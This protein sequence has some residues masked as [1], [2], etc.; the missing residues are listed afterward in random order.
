MFTCH[1]TS[2]WPTFTLLSRLHLLVG[3]HLP[4][5]LLH[6]VNDR[7]QAWDGGHVSILSLLDLSA[8]FDTIDHDILIKRL[9]TTFGFSGTVLDWF[10]SYLSFRTQSVFLGQLRPF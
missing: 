5:G 7:L 9:H 3:Q 6:V 4:V 1:F 2:F 10:T 8:A